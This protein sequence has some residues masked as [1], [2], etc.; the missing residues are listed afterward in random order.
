MKP[1]AVIGFGLRFPESTDPGSF[2]DV[3]HSGRDTSRTV[4]EDRWSLSLAEALGGP[5]ISP[6]QVRSERGCFV[7]PAVGDLGDLDPELAETV[8][9]SVR[10]AV[11]A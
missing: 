6:D 2:W 7:D 4:P 5:T 10:L 3:I 8:D 1:I 9:P 11:I